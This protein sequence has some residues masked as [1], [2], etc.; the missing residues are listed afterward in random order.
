MQDIS[1][2]ITAIIAALSTITAIIV[3]IVRIA[4][5]KRVEIDLDHDG[6]ADIVIPEVATKATEIENHTKED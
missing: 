1:A 3:V 4:N 2:L 5:G 6:I